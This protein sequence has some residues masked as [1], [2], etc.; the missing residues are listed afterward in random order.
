MLE[1]RCIERLRGLA[2][3]SLERLRELGFSSLEDRRLWGDLIVALQ[4]VEGTSRKDGEGALT[5]A[6][7]AGQGGMDLN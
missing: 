4:C 5:R 2:I 1:K 3:F 7:S 6:W